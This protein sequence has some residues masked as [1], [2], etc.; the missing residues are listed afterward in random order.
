M[1]NRI[2]ADLHNHFSTWSEGWGNF[3]DI[4]DT[5][6]KNFGQGVV[7]LSNCKDNRYETFVDSSS[8]NSKYERVEIGGDKNALFVPEKNLLIVRGQEVFTEQGH[9]LVL[10]TPKKHRIASEDLTDVVK[11][12]ND[13]GAGTI[14]IHP[15]FQGTGKYL[16]R[17]PELL[18]QID[19]I[20]IY[21]ASLELFS[22]FGK[23][24][25]GLTKR[26]FIHGIHHDLGCCAFTDGH[27]IESIGTSYTM[28]PEL[29]MNSSQALRSSLKK[30]LEQ[31][32]KKE[33]LVKNS[34]IIDSFIHGVQLGSWTLKEKLL[35]RG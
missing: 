1:T 5:I 6:S 28:I 20:E 19:S 18:D 31:T 27:S 29:N 13:I 34:A 25:N 3:D 8:G 16:E 14:A 33:H 11:E 35:G 22:L 23:N 32:I 7:G 9:F 30:A 12:A 21:N 15:Y 26:L 4:I 2:K 24:Y 17:H 10:G